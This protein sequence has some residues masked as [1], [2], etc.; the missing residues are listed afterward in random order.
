MRKNPT[1][2]LK[3]V[4]GLD[5][6]G[7]IH[8]L[9][10]TRNKLLTWVEILKASSMLLEVEDGL[11][12]EAS[13]LFFMEEGNRFVRMHDVVR[14]VAKTIA[15]KDPHHRF[16]VKGDVRLQEWEKRDGELR[17]CTGISL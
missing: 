14:D 5:L 16:A 9:E 8:S 4:M 13:S 6:F 10:Q 17:N 3:Y 2:L 11:N 12:C 1:D 7:Y 15:S